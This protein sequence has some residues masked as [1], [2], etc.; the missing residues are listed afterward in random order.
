M[1]A[2]RGAVVPDRLSVLHVVPYFPPDRMGGVGE[3]VAHV[4]E[5]LVRAG[6]RSTVLTS[7]TIRNEPS[8]TREG[9]SPGAFVLRCAR[10]AELARGADVVHI[11]HGE[12]LGVLL[13][14]R[15]LGIGTPVLLTLHVDVGQLRR[16][17]LPV[18]VEGRR[19]GGDGTGFLHD[20]V[21]MR[22]REQLDRA[23]RALADRT[24]F[25][26]RS[27]AL[28]V[29]GPRG[30]HAPVV[31]N[32]I[33]PRDDPE[34]P[35]TQR[36]PEP[37][38]MLYVGAASTRKRVELLPMVLARVRALRPDAR[39]RVVGFGPDDHAGFVRVA[40]ELGVLRAIVFEGRKLSGELGPYYWAASVLVVPSAYEGLPMVILE[41]YRGGLPCVATRV[42]GHPEVTE[43]GRT[44]LLVRPDSPAEMAE[45][46]LALLDDPDR[47]RRMGEE[48]R[49]LVESRFGV[50]RQVE[51]YVELYG[52]LRVGAP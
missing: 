28:D 7:G 5:G 32:G 42:S 10:R 26:S 6:H 21:G 40:R 31:Y 18:V 47:A 4:H 15:L 46:I 33:P 51:E 16:S 11:H 34:G 22:V 25:I 3:V 50:E 20:V 14:M 49:A 44:G 36:P 17:S 52:A 27:A 45:S 13:A 39:L 48:G 29:L 8:V 24:T 23:A 37:V 1:A 9:A 19:I 30:A 2:E 43:H 38:E 35:T 41:A 12:G